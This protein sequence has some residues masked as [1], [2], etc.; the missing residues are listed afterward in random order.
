MHF[1]STFSKTS[2]DGNSTAKG[3]QNF[4]LGCLLEK[5]K[6]LKITMCFVELLSFH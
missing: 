2:L 3:G 6:N 1:S 4:F 5:K